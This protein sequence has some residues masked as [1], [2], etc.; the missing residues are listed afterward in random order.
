VIASFVVIAS[1]AACS[2]SNSTSDP[3]ASSASPA[4]RAPALDAAPAVSDA[5]APTVAAARS[6]EDARA[7]ARRLHDRAMTALAAKQLDDAAQIWREAAATDPTWS[8][9]PYNLACVAAL[10]GHSDDAI[11]QLRLMLD[12]APDVDLLR[13]LETDHDFGSVRTLAAFQKLVGEVAKVALARGFN[14]P[15]GGAIAGCASMR[16][17][18]DGAYTYECATCCRYTGRYSYAKG[19]LQ[20]V[21]SA[22]QV[23]EMGYGKP[24]RID[25][26]GTYQLRAVHGQVCFDRVSATGV[27]DDLPWSPLPDGCWE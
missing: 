8:W 20:L 21:I 12:R 16:F 24:R 27:T 25:V 11:A 18:R 5:A 7:E 14:P 1:P 19:W 17:T 26:R 9:P 3:G 22:V 6:P 15:Q 23:E 2:R 4:P 10:Q 13:R